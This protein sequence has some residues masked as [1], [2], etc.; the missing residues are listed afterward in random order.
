MALISL[1]VVPIA[2]T[3]LS[4]MPVGSNPDLYVLS[5]PL[6]QGRDGLAVFAF[7][8]GFSSAT[9]MVIVAALALSTMISNQIVMP[10]WLRYT[11]G[12]ASI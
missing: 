2:V 1:F 7:L 5:L 4:L 6:S 9:S 11:G 10:L 3:G 12:R 8:G